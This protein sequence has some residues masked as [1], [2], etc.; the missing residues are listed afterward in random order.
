VSRNDAMCERESPPHKRKR[1]KRRDRPFK[2]EG[3]FIGQ[4]DNTWISRMLEESR[5]WHTVGAYETE[6]GR[7]SALTAFKR[8]TWWNA[9][10]EYRLAE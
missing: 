5:D 4:R 10:W 8:N 7:S 9:Q 6:R 2:I 3:R 1:G